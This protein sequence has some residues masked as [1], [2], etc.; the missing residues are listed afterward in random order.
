MVRHGAGTPERGDDL[1][2]VKAKTS[3]TRVSEV[4]DRVR[5]FVEVLKMG[6]AMDWEIAQ[7]LFAVLEDLEKRA[8][9]RRRR[10]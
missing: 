5:G 3:V 8:N 1:F 9:A 2:R 6:G 4:G 7:V 10:A